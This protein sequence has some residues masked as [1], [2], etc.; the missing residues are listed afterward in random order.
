[1]WLHYKNML[2][3]WGYGRGNKFKGVY[4]GGVFSLLQGGTV[5]GWGV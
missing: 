1:M 3:L 2:Y 5:Q 4:G